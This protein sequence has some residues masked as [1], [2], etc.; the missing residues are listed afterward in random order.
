MRKLLLL[1]SACYITSDAQAQLQSPPEVAVTHSFPIRYCEDKQHKQLQFIDKHAAVSKG[2]AKTTS[3]MPDRWYYYADYMRLKADHDQATIGGFPDYID[4]YAPFMWKDTFGVIGYTNGAAHCNFTSNGFILD[5]VFPGFNRTDLYD[6]VYGSGNYIKVA[7]SNS[8]TWDSIYING[9]YSGP[10]KTPGVVD[11]LRIALLHDVPNSSD[12]STIF[13]GF[14]TTSAH[15][16]TINFLTL[17]FD[18]INT[19]AVTPKAPFTAYTGSN[20]VTY[21]DILLK[22]TDTSSFSITKTFPIVQSTT[23]GAIGRQWFDKNGSLGSGAFIDPVTPINV[24][25]TT[26]GGNQLLAATVTFISGDPQT[27]GS[28]SLAGLPGDTLVSFLALPNWR[29]NVFQQ[30]IAFYTATDPST[31][32]TLPAADWAPYDVTNLNAGLFKK[33]PY[34]PISGKYH[35]YSPNWSWTAGTPAGPFYWQYP[36]IGFHIHC[37]SC[38]AVPLQSEQTIL[39]NNISATPNPAG[40]TLHISYTLAKA[41]DISVT[42][43]NMLGQTVNRQTVRNSTSGTVNINT[44]GIPQGIYIY[45]LEANGERTTGQVSVIH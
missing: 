31:V 12:Q 43:S 19:T 29:Y 41:T 25:G 16:G 42:L 23:P 45:S 10:S 14:L 9:F 13:S 5:P 30:R 44:A 21:M 32:T 8:Y 17:Q 40:N 15:Y 22:T 3:L 2:A 24:A 26:S 36:E 37:P 38:A 28:G 6:I 27:H 35:I 34:T 33:M 7:A 4:S 11:T 20:P 1:L 39:T 18:S